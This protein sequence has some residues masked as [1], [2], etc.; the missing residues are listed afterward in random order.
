MSLPDI[1]QEWRN[2]TRRRSI[3]E[4]PQTTVTHFLRQS[5]EVLI[6]R[7]QLSLE[8]LAPNELLI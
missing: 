6:E 1:S 8:I 5:E 2:L 3:G 4:R 7:L